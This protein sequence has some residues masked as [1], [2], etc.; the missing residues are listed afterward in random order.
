MELVLVENGKI[1]VTLD[2]KRQPLAVSTNLKKSIHPYDSSRA[3]NRALEELLHYAVG[4]DEAVG[5]DEILIA[6]REGILQIFEWVAEFCALF[7][8][9]FSKNGFDVMMQNLAQRSNSFL[10]QASAKNGMGGRD[11]IESPV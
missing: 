5:N 11:T 6:S 8:V 7:E 9:V 4:Y 1:K 2:G 10:S 3:W